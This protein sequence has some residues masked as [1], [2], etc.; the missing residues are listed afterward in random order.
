M[1]ICKT[2][3]FIQSIILE[4][5]R[6]IQHYRWSIQ[7]CSTEQSIGAS[8]VEESDGREESDSGETNASEAAGSSSEDGEDSTLARQLDFG[9]LEGSLESASEDAGSANGASSGPQGIGVLLGSAASGRPASSTAAG[10]TGLSGSESSGSIASGSLADDLD[11]AAGEA[12]ANGSMRSKEE[13]K[14]EV[15]L[16]SSKPR[17]SGGA[18]MPTSEDEEAAAAEGP[19]EAEEG[20]ATLLKCEAVLYQ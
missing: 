2:S 5:T 12:A 6:I 8:D 17:T 14:P 15:E 9:H 4:N 7:L 1:D 18:D 11:V 10:S 16:E 13:S 3:S 19:I 20:L